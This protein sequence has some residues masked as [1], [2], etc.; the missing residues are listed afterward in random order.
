M[1]Q[2]LGAGSLGVM[3]AVGVILV[4]YGYRGPPRARQLPAFLAFILFSYLT[5][6]ELGHGWVSQSIADL[7]F[8]LKPFSGMALVGLLT[9]I[10]L[11]STGGGWRREL[12]L[13][14]G[15]LL[16]SFAVFCP[17]YSVLAPS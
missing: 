7:N 15:S 8:W 3:F 12:S 16:A 17:L 6:R 2:V 9:N 14:V 1:D 10:L 13:F 11:P 4:V 5:F